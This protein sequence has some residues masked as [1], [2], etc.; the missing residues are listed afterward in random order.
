VLRAVFVLSFFAMLSVQSGAAQP[1]F[2]DP[3]DTPA[4]P[5]A[6]ATS[7]ALTAITRAGRRLVAAGPR[8]HILLSD[9]AGRRWRQAAVP[10][11]SDLTAVYFPNPEKGWAVGHDGIVLHSRDGGLHWMKQMDGRQ[12]AALAL[13]Y[14]ARQAK[15]GNAEA[16]R[17][18][19]EARRLAA[20]GADK[21]FLD[22]W[23]V[24]ERVGY[25]LGAFNMIFKTENGGQSWEPWLHRID[26]PKGHHL[27]A[28][29][30]SGKALYIVGELGLV[31]R[32]EPVR[33]RFVRVATP[34][35]GSYFGM[36]VKAD[37][38]LVYGLRGNAWRSRDGG[39]N[40]SRCDIGIS[41]GITGAAALDDG[42]LVLVAQ[43]GHV[44]ASRDDG[45]SFTPV[46]IAQ[47]APF[48]GV[49][50]AGSDAIAIVGMRGVRVE[51]VQ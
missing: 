1:K 26:N 41:S 15:A 45:E 31:L 6:L 7:S 46:R 42:R 2:S 39:R 48:H 32:L 49:A 34:Y 13:Q 24:D 9:D 36:L 51:R 10:V 38:I 12:A 16:E 40:W 47:P 5:S 19:P 25:V 28:M 37:L 4:M 29:R 35:Q 8:G 44:L 21:P 33:Q 23:F 43:S 27:Y 22:V 3:L 17:V 20:E 30:G 18:L 14:Y 50:Q 11:S